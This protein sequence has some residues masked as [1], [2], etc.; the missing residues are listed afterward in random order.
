MFYPLVSPANVNDTLVFSN[1]LTLPSIV[2]GLGPPGQ[3]NPYGTAGAIAVSQANFPT[4][5]TCGNLTSQ[6]FVIWDTVSPTTFYFTGNNNFCMGTISVNPGCVL[7]SNCAIAVT[8]LGT[9]S[10]YT[11]ISLMDISRTTDGTHFWIAGHSGGAINDGGCASSGQTCDIFEVTINA[12]GGAATTATFAAAA[13]TTNYWHKLQMAL[14]Q[15]FQVEALGGANVF[16]EYNSNGTSYATLLTSH[17]DFGLCADGVN[18]C[19]FGTWSVGTASN[20]CPH[21]NGLASVQTSNTTA[22]LCLLEA[23][24]PGNS[25]Y[26][27]PPSYAPATHVSATANNG[28]IAVVPQS[29]ASGACPN[30]NNPYCEQGAGPTNMAAWGLYDGEIL[31]IKVDGTAIYRLGFHYSRSATCYWCATGAAFGMSGNYLYFAS[32][33]NSCPISCGSQTTTTDQDYEDMYVLSLYANSGAPAPGMLM[34][35]LQRPHRP[36]A[37][38]PKNMN[39]ANRQKLRGEKPETPAADGISRQ[40]VIEMLKRPTPYIVDATGFWLERKRQ[41]KQAA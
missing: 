37:P 28:W 15:R 41:H 1:L 6:Q 32:N 10:S 14:G 36:S 11:A 29:Y 22:L 40:N 8:V 17:H 27:V 12:T 13:I 23:F 20:P 2:L 24:L 33:F 35:K 19:M 34:S 21:E 26:G 7:T 5:G 3:G 4:S 31:D 39:K 38:T 9:N 18:E 25:V 16:T 30:T